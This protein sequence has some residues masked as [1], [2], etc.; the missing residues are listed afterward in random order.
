M[1]P[2]PTV[3]HSAAASHGRRSFVSSML[4]YLL[5]AAGL[6]VSYSEAAILYTNSGDITV[7]SGSDSIFLD[8][9]H[10]SAGPDYASTTSFAGSDVQLFFRFGIADKPS[11][12]GNANGVSVGNYIS[13]LSSGDLISSASPMSYAL[14]MDGVI[15][16]FFGPDEATPASPWD[17]GGEGYLG[18]WWN[19]PGGTRYG[20]AQVAWDDT[21]KA[22]TLKDFAV[23]TEAGVAIRAGDVGLVPEPSHSLLLAIGMAG[24]LLRRKRRLPSL[25]ARPY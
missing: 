17:G 15:T 11:L 10:N 21:S 4:A 2:I 23:E 14:Q 12:G 16:P 20:W 25:Q 5:A 19:A 18:I 9:D 7:S 8:L 3:A 24:T 22:L 13:K 1:K 6:A